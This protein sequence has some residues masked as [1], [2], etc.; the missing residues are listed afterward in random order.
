MEVADKDFGKVGVILGGPSRER[1]VSIR[2][3]KA[4]ASALRSAGLDIVEIG[5]KEDIVQGVLEAGIDVAFLALHGRYGEDGTIQRFLE[6]RGIPYTGS[7]PEASLAGLY[8]VRAKELFRDAGIPTPDWLVVR[9]GELP[10][11][12]RFVFPVVIKPVMEG[13]SIG[14]TIVNDRESLPDALDL[15][16][17]MGDEVLLETYVPGREITVGILGENALPVVQID[18]ARSFYDFE[19]KYQKGHTRYLVPA[20]IAPALTG[21]IQ[22]L[23][24][25][26]HRAV[27]CRDFS[28]VDM[29]LG[30]E[31]SP[32]V[33]EVNTIP[34]FTET[35]LLPK[36]AAAQGID[37]TGLCLRILNLCKQRREHEN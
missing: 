28:R 20:P 22:E 12:R 1:E 5:E 37:F 29:I 11:W 26:A 31:D 18:T 2:S 6:Q 25:A 14:L 4:I 35:S 9:R 23:G 30:P 36:A 27:G 32:V 34:G 21:R 17:S 19:A 8:K 3:G 13:S 24:L 16:F 7:G 15:A 10:D 33:L